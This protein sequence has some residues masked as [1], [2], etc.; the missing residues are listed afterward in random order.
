MRASTPSASLDKIRT[1][2][3]VDLMERR[4]IK[5]GL[6]ILFFIGVFLSCTVGSSALER[7]GYDEAA[8]LLFAFSFFSFVPIYTSMRAIFGS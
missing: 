6:W 3:F 7:A 8:M 2:R 5:K 4:E 1:S